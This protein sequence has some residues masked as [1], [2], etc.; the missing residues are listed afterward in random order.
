M[1][2]GLGGGVRIA[3]RGLEER[4]G[5]AG[6]ASHLARATS[7][8]IAAMSSPGPV[9][10]GGAWLT[11]PAGER[12]YAPPRYCLRSVSEAPF[13]KSNFRSGRTK[14]SRSSRSVSP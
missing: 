14:P 4:A 10:A 3:C 12:G 6:R 13:V 9:A 2:V 1:R 8:P 11:S 5:G 7:A